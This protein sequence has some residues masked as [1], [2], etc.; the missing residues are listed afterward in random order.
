MGKTKEIFSMGREEGEIIVIS[1]AKWDGK[2]IHVVNLIDLCHL[3]NVELATHLQKYKE[4]VVLRVHRPRRRW[5]QASLMA[6]L[7]RSFL[8]GCSFSVH[9][10]QKWPM[11][12]TLKNHGVCVARGNL[13]V[14]DT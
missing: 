12:P 14:F 8:E 4:R 1:Q 3:K 6:T 9:S 5:M 13:R 11:L 7:S 2:T 10:C